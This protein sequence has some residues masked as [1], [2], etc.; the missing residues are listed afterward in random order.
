MPYSSS[1]H[2]T[3]GTLLTHWQS[4][5][6]YSRQALPT[7]LQ[8]WVEVSFPHRP[9]SMP[10]AEAEYFV[11]CVLEDKPIEGA[12]SPRRARATQEVIEA[13]YRSAETGRPVALPL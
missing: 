4:L 9:Y 8:G 6:L 12:V 11:N 1:Y 3:D 10:L 13:A 7:D 2:G 5:S